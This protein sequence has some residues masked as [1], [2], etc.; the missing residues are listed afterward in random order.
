MASFFEREA[1]RLHTTEKAALPVTNFTQTCGELVMI[2][3]EFRPVWPLM[4][5]PHLLTL[6]G[7]CI[8]YSPH[9]MRII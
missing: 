1:K 3:V 2:P 8:D 7:D 5:G 6:Y 4:D 9:I